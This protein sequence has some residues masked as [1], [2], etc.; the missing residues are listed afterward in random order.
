VASRGPIIGVWAILLFAGLVPTETRAAEPCTLKRWADQGVLA[1]GKGMGPDLI[2]LIAEAEWNA[3]ASRDPASYFVRVT[4]PDGRVDTRPFPVDYPP[5]R[6]RFTVFILADLVQDLA[7]SAVKVGVSVVDASTGSTLSNTLPLT[8]EDLPRPRGDASASDNGPFGRGKP[9]EGPTRILP[10]PGPD[11]LRFAR[12]PGSEGSPGFFVATTEA[13]VGQVGKRLSGYDPKAG[14][15]DEFALEDS[16]QPAIN[17]NP[18]KAALYLDALSKSD[19]SGLTYRLP[20]I[21][22]WTQAARGGK[23]SAF[24]W[25]DDP[26]FPAGANLLGPEPALPGETTAPAQPPEASPS[27]ESNPFGLAH[28]FGN[29]AEWATDPAVGFARMGGNFRTEPASPL[30]FVKVGTAEEIGPDPFVGVRPVVELS[31]ESATVAI[32]KRLAEDAKLTGVTVTYDPDRAV[33]TL[34]GPV[35][36]ATSRRSAD[37]L[38][39]GLWFVAA[40]ENRL[41]TPAL[42]PSQ[43]AILGATSGA[44]RRHAVLD[45]SFVEMTIPVRWL[46]PLP[47]AG[48]SWWL[49]LSTPGGSLPAQKLTQGEPG[50]AGQLTVQIDRGLLAAQGLADTTPIRVALSLGAPAPTQGDPS[51]VSN[52]VEIRPAAA[53]R[54]TPARGVR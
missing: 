38:L 30:P 52:A 4:Y 27:F 10:Q 49:N 32:R 33:A 42:F 7:P 26:T 36:D 1:P 31:P 22:E 54:P 8:I 12:V 5:G 35:A 14:R 34:T 51:I 44:T 6:P 39:E 40:V 20:T 23:P 29:A 13:S 43:L 41:E 15:S 45:R 46:D 53:V 19:P 37:R 50:N 2:K 21:F 16:D 3:S 11:G 18:A 24:W 48:T 25:G 28:T 47:V 9:L 17:L